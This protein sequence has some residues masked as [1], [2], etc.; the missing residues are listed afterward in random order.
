[1]EQENVEVIPAFRHGLLDG[2]LDYLKY[3]FELYPYSEERDPRYYKQLLKDFDDLDLLEELKQYH[4][5]I[6][7]QPE[8]KK[9]S[10]RCRFRSWLKTAQGFKRRSYFSSSYW[11]SK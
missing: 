9:I 11:R 7:D 8:E 4:A 5:W 1:M 3:D 2:L 10:Y 6:L